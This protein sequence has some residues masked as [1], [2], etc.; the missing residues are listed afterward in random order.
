MKWHKSASRLVDNENLGHGKSWHDLLEVERHQ[1]AEYLTSLLMVPPLPSDRTGSLRADAHLAEERTERNGRRLRLTLHSQRISL[2]SS[3]SAIISAMKSNPDPKNL[4]RL[5]EIWDLVVFELLGG[6]QGLK[7]WK[8]WNVQNYN[9]PWRLWPEFRTIYLISS[10]II[11]INQEHSRDKNIGLAGL[12]MGT[13]LILNSNIDEKFRIP[14]S[15]SG[16][17]KSWNKYRELIPLIA[18]TV[19]CLGGAFRPAPR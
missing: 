6:I 12:Q 17:R 2:R 13:F 15:S 4:I 18:A 8:S 3:L 7:R 1:H 9:V 19:H 14:T 5:P 16:V 11:R 10:A